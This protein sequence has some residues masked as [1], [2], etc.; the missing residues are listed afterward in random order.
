LYTKAWDQ[1]I[2]ELAVITHDRPWSLKRLLDSVKQ[3][4][5]FGDAVNVVINLEQTADLETRHIA[6]SFTMGFNK[7]NVAVRHRIV[8]AGLMTAVVESW[9]PH[10]NHSYGKHLV[11]L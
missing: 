2:I 1:P 9:H 4:Q 10:G 8:Y 5:Y 3:A 7:G 11:F 6:E